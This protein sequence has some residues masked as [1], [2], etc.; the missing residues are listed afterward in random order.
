[1]SKVITCILAGLLLIS[2]N[3]NL[4]NDPIEEL[5]QLQQRIDEHQA[6]IQKSMSKKDSVLYK[7]IDYLQEKLPEYSLPNGHLNHY[8][9]SLD[10]FLNSTDPNSENWNQQEEFLYFLPGLVDYDSQDKSNEYYNSQISRSISYKPF[11]DNHP[12]YQQFLNQISKQYPDSRDS[13]VQCMANRRT[14]HRND[15][16]HGPSRSIPT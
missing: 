11:L 5:T 3:G 15:G 1:M 16:A 9:K 12:S 13:M 14:C 4:P 6:R 2:A 10:H 8:L 7:K